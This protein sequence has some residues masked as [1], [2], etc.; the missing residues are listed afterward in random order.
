MPDRAPPRPPLPVAELRYRNPRTGQ[1][2]HW[3]VP[4]PCSP[5]L[6]RA[7]EYALEQ[8]GYVRMD[9]EAS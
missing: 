6:L 9:D 4:A 1:E 5:D 2:I 3:T 7:M 8:R